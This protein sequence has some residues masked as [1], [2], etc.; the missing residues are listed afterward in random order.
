MTDKVSEHK[1]N[2]LQFL[3]PSFIGLALI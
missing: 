3:L 1:N 2:Y